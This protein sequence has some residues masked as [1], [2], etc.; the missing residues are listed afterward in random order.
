MEILGDHYLKEA[1]SLIEK[2][3]LKRMDKFVSM[4]LCVH[5]NNGQVF[6]I[7]NGGSASTASHFANDLSKFCSVNGK[8]R[9]RAISLTDNVSTMTAYA[10]DA[11]YDK[12]FSEQLKNLVNKGDILVC[13]TASGNSPN[14]LEAIKAAKEHGA[15]AFGFLGFDGGK[16]KNM[17]DDY[18]I[19][20]CKDF[21]LVESLHLLLEHLAV[22]MIRRRLLGED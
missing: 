8:K 2:I 14:I 5:E 13:F 12:I 19:V 20:E 4:V 16:A 15:L 10:N 22:N 11:S 6:I 3:D 21:G 18:V 17:A 9:F 1:R 7:G